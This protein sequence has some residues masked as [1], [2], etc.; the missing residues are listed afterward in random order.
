M[1]AR[2]NLND[3]LP[4]RHVTEGSGSAR[5]SGSG[6]PAR[7][8][9]AAPIDQASAGIAKGGAFDLFD[10]GDVFKRTPYIADLKPAGRFVAKDLS[11]AGTIPLVMKT[12][13][14]NG[15]LHGECSTA[16]GWSVTEK[17]HGTA[18]NLN[19][20]GDRPVSRPLRLCGNLAPARA[21]VDIGGSIGRFGTGKTAIDAE[22]GRLDAGVSDTEFEERPG[23]RRPAFGSGYL[24]RFSRQAGA[25]HHSAVARPAGSAEKTC[26]ADI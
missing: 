25:A 17:L 8:R 4:A 23:G 5:R 6:N 3:R 1:D 22:C 14:E 12:L 10:G 26:Y 21:T 11:D 9:R 13:S 2:T 24:W 19:R 16:T 7:G 20:D 18:W 15:F